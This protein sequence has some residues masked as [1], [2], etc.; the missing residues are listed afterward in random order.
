MVRMPPLPRGVPSSSVT[1]PLMSVM[2]RLMR[3]PE[4]KG[5]L[6]SGLEWPWGPGSK[7][8]FAA[9]QGS[10]WAGL[11]D[12]YGMLALAEPVLDPDAHLDDLDA[13]RRGPLP[14][15][16]GT[17]G[18]LRVA[19]LDDGAGRDVRRRFFG[20]GFRRLRGGGTCPADGDGHDAEV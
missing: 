6:P 10:H 7:C 5:W 18:F 11:V 15:P 16:R 19:A 9:E 17:D 1:P 8:P 12:V 13:L 3:S 4:W 14:Q 20:F 2:S